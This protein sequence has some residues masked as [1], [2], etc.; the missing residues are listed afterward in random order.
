[1]SAVLS[2]SNVSVVRGRHQLLK[3]VTFSVGEDERWVVMGPNGAG[4]STLIRI[5]S[6]RMFPTSGTVDVLGQRMGRVDL[7][8]LRPAIGVASAALGRE[9]REEETALNTVVTAAYGMTGRWREHYDPEDERRALRLLSQWGAGTLLSRKFVTLSE[10][11][12]AR[13]L[14]ARALMS[15]PEL[16]LLDEPAA[17]LDL[18]G[19]EDLVRRLGEFAAQP[20][21]P[22]MV[23]VTHHLEE[24]PA[25]FTHALLLGNGGI[26]ASGP[27]E[28]T[29]TVANL[30]AAFGLKLS[31][32][33]ANGRFTAFAR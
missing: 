19:R 21:A 14:I 20:A 27:L 30:E 3:D 24:I 13:V 26:V 18:A 29:M 16:M 12:R 10:G 33:R 31:L 4:K 2:F 17:G 23:L 11:E 32:T 1:M 5:A 28:E 9:V 6:T 25:N 22:T 8:E 15:D 7:S